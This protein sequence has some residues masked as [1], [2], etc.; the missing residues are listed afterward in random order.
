MAPSSRDIL[1]IGAGV[2]GLSTAA[3]LRGRGRAVTVVD[4]GGPNA[5]SVAAGMIA[6][7]MESAVERVEPERADLLRAAAGLWPAFAA[8][9]G[10]TLSPALAEWRG[11]RSEEI[12]ERL[13]ALGFA[14][15]AMEGGVRAS[16]DLR[17]SPVPALARLADGVDR[18]EGRVEAVLPDGEGW[19][20]DL[21]DGRILASSAVVV[22][23]GA[24]TMKAAPDALREAQNLVFPVRGQIG[25][26]A[27]PLADRT[28]RGQGG[29]VTPVE[30]GVV[31][32]ATM[33]RGRRDLVPD[34]ETGHRLRRAA[35]DLLETLIDPA[36]VHWRV[37]IRGAS[38]DGLPLAGRIA[39]GLF[40]ALAPRRNGWLLGPLVG[41]IVAD[42]IE[43][44][45]SRKEAAAFNPLRFSRAG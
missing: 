18:V 43:G 42:A 44:R 24:E 38:A 5:S 20:I 37:G 36:A 13:L 40:V 22:A 1:I 15:E 2:L 6:P 32:G 19:R 41:E 33:D 21:A 28:I 10:V 25:F 31:V 4:P 26:V 12:H 17:V 8:A 7:A 9:H 14:A 11:D 45:A 23:A 27:A 39:P 34:P 35:E 3:I 30:G 29:Y 16:D